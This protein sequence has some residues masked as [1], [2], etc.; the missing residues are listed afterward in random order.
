MFRSEKMAAG[1]LTAGALVGAPLAAYH[2]YQRS[3]GSAL[4]AAAWAGL[5]LVAGPVVLPVALVQGFGKAGPCPGDPE[6]AL[7]RMG[8][9]CDCLP[10]FVHSSVG[11]L[12]SPCVEVSIG[13]AAAGAAIVAQQIACRAGGQ[14]F[15][16]VSGACVAALPGTSRALPIA[17]VAVSG[18]AALGLA[19]YAAKAKKRTNPRRRRAAVRA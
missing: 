6:H 2:G 8:E 1:Y 5:G 18:A 16:P 12:T 11:D 10:G 7:A 9:G 19:V 13:G 4:W 15:D 3:G 14:V 17:I